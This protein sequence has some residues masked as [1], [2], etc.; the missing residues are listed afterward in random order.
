MP[1]FMYSIYVGNYESPS[2]AKKR[3]CQIERTWA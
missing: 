1:I 3:Y 2:K